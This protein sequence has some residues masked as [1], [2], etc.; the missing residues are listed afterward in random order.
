MAKKPI[1]TEQ[2]VILPNI[3]W[4]KF[5]ALIQE[6]G[7]ERQTRLSYRRGKLELMTPVPEHDRCHKLIESLIMVL[8]DE[9]NLEVTELAPV[10]LKDQQLDCA[11]EPDACY[12]FRDEPAIK[13]RTELDL[14]QFPCPDLL[15]E[16]ALTK[17]NLEKLP[18]YAT[19]GI[20]EVWCYLTTAGEDVLKG[21]L[22]I[23]QLQGSEYLERRNSL[24][25][26]FL[27]GDRVVEFLEQSDSMSLAT[28]LRVL[29]AW[30]TETLDS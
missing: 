8:V 9:L 5:E 11:T 29:R 2:R 13:N 21:T 23:Y 4:Q 18:I 19:L 27:T 15:V 14:T 25:F 17:S 28:A 7:A 10:L 12:Y 1:V 16:V 3:N 6:L 22:K 20:P 24:T 30:A 26:P